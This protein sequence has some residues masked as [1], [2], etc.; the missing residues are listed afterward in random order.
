MIAGRSLSPAGRSPLVWARA[1]CRRWSLRREE[2]VFPSDCQHEPVTGITHAALVLVDEA[3]H[4]PQD[5]NPAAVAAVMRPFLA[6]VEVPSID[7]PS[8]PSTLLGGRGA[9]TME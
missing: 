8:G 1:R 7:E 9:T 5:E 2:Y 6:G 4:N 3:G